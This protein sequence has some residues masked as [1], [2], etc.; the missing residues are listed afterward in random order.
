MGKT[1]PDST[2]LLQFSLRL[3]EKAEAIRL[4]GD[5]KGKEGRCSL[6]RARKALMG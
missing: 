2:A 4:K 5:Q 1:L 6:L 3:R